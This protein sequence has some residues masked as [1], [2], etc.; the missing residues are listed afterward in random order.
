[1]SW[2]PKRWRDELLWRA[3]LIEVLGWEAGLEVAAS[4]YDQTLISLTTDT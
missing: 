1:M 2:L 4:G 3:R